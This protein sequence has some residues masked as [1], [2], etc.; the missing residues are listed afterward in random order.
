MNNPCYWGFSWSRERPIKPCFTPC[1]QGRSWDKCMFGKGA[2]DSIYSEKGLS[3]KQRSEK[4]PNFVSENKIKIVEENERIRLSKL[5]QL[6]R[7]EE[8]IDK[9]LECIK[10]D[11]GKS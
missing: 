2:E 1:P 7:I 9:L 3:Y 8:K 6:D 4:D 10:K 11:K 5:S